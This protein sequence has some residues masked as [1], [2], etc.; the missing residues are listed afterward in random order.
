MTK[1]TQSET[2]N[3]NG[4][5]THTKT[6]EYDNGKVEV[7]TRVISHGFFFDD[8]VSESHTTYYKKK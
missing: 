7:D 2:P 8:K 1:V 3:K 4:T 6:T 5:C